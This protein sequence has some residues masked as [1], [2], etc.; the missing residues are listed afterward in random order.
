MFEWNEK[1]ERELIYMKDI[2]KKTYKQI[3]N[4]IHTT[5]SS[6]KHKYVRLK[7]ANN[8]DKYHHP[9]EKTEQVV[10]LLNGS[11]LRILETNAGYGNMTQVYVQ[12]GSVISHDIDNKKIKYLNELDLEGVDVIKCDS[13]IRLHKYI[14]EKRKFDV[15]DLDPYGY[16]SRYFPH[17]FELIDDGILFVTFPKMGVQQ[18]NKIQI[19]HYRV[20]WDISLSDKNNYTDKII[21]KIT[22][23]AMQNYRSINLL[24]CV[25]LGRMYRFAFRVKRE[26]AL[27]LVGLE[28]NRNI[29][30]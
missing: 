9:A 27:D 7:Q 14:Y 10:K 12:Y 21:R 28:V 26:S 20:F 17:V 16:P 24:D 25:D 19:E 18:V 1:T 8:E 6:V 13:F 5:V 22:D 4:E 3:A 29:K 23:Y 15:V 30:P 2:E 11:D